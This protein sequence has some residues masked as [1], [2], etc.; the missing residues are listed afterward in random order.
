MPTPGYI[1]AELDK[2][3]ILL[4]NR[5]IVL[6]GELDDAP[7]LYEILHGP[8]IGKT[9]GLLAT[10]FRGEYS[11]VI[12]GDVGKKICIGYSVSRV[13]FSYV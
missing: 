8:V 10:S 6:G 5:F 7:T 2:N 1:R 13:L 3:E 4:P 11:D 12:S 9:V